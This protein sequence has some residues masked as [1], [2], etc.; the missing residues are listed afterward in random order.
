[1]RDA[2]SPASEEDDQ[3]ADAFDLLPATEISLDQIQVRPGNVLVP[4]R[5]PHAL[6]HVAA[7]LRAAGDRD[8]VVMTVRLVDTDCPGTTP[9]AK[10]R[11]RGYERQLLS[12]V[13]AVAERLGRPVRLLIVPARNV[14]EAIVTTVLRLRSSDVYVG[15]SSTLSAEDQARLLG[16]AWERADKPEA[17]GRPPGDRSPQRTR[18]YLSPGRASAVA[19]A[20]RP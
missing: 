9:P 7:A 15:E 19:L 3:A 1:M 10:A 17:A 14:V 13:V 16:D 11:R 6:D 5:N 4:V 20:R 8:V 2:T 18:A 12:E